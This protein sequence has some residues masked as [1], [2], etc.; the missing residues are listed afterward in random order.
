MCQSQTPGFDRIKAALESVLLGS[1]LQDQLGTDQSHLLAGDSTFL[2]VSHELTVFLAKR[3][4]PDIIWR[5]RQFGNI[6][7]LV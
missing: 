7:W 6:H 5:C 2:T 4:V 1:N 3:F